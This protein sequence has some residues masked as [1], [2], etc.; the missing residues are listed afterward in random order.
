MFDPASV[1][2]RGQ[3]VPYVPGFWS[4][5]IEQGYE[6]LSAGNLLRLA[7][8][9]SRW[10]DDRSL[11]VRNLD[12]ERIAEFLA[13]RKRKRY[14]AF[15]SPRGLQPLLTYLRSLGV[16]PPA[17]EPQET[18]LDRWLREYGEYL[19]QERGLVSA[20]IR[21]YTDFAR[22]FVDTRLGSKPRS[23]SKLSA[24]DVTRFISREFVQCSSIATCKLTVSQLRSLLRY[25]HVQGWSK[26]DLAACVPAVAGRRLASVPKGLEPAQVE[27]VLASCDSQTLVGCRD[28]SVL[29]LLVRLALRCCEVARLHL[30]DIDWRAG[31]IMVRGKASHESRLPLP[32]DV[33]EALVAYLRCRPRVDFRAVFLSV[34][35]PY[36]P[37]SSKAVSELA[38]HRMHAAAVTGGAHCL[39][40][41]AAPPR[42][43]GTGRPSPKSVTSCAIDTSIRQRSTP[44]STTP[45]SAWS[46]VHG[47]EVAHEVPLK[48]SR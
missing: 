30:E 45:V 40:H 34:R 42:C 31:E 1:R 38:A 18:P 19:A 48:S 7:A 11:C 20:T 15:L 12:D 23:W 26:Q 14:T 17:L 46:R 4:S 13:H 43:S 29:H 6:P 28:R 16:A 33:G 27:Q 32:H 8:H 47:R 39:R 37:I 10:L 44:R 2:F 9:L 35:A 3:L 41:T 25:V 21:A 22:R 5:L 36:R 24:A